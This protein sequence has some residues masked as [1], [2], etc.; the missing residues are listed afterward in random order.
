MTGPQNP[1]NDKQEFTLAGAHR[2]MAPLCKG[3]WQK[4]PIFDWGI[5]CMRNNNPSEPPFGG[6]PP[7]TQGR[8]WW[9]LICTLNENL[10][11]EICYVI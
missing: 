10:H 3:G 1:A 6:P 9:A 5:V 7:F 8:L 11:Q 2:P 4:S